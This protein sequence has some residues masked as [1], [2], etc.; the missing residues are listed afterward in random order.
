MNFN[1]F[2][3]IHYFLESLY[4]PPLNVS[5]ST[6]DGTYGLY[7]FGRVCSNFKRRFSIPL[8][9]AVL[10]KE[11]VIPATPLTTITGMQALRA[12]VNIGIKI[13]FSN[14]CFFKDF[15]IINEMF[16]CYIFLGLTVVCYCIMIFDHPFI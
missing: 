16:I 8:I 10:S 13:T 1:R 7:G 3:G 4:K 12:R 6:K 11:S 15:S 2:F 14:V 5:I 9:F